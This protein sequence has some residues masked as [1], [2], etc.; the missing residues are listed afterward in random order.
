MIILILITK[1]ESKKMK[2]KIG[3][4]AVTRTLGEG[5]YGKVKFATT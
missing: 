2:Q 5:A 3:Q 4:Y 1:R